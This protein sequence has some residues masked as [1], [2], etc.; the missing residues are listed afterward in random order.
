MFFKVLHLNVLHNIVKK[1][2]LLRL[3]SSMFYRWKEALS[4][5]LFE[6][7]QLM[8]ALEADKARLLSKYFSLWFGNVNS[9]LI[10]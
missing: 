10:K 5:K 3:R 9:D 8:L 1:K 4:A 2:T 6:E 7:K